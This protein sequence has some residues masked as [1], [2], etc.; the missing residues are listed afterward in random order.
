MNCQAVR[1]HWNLYHDSEGDGELHFRINEHLGACP[2]CAQWFSQ[3]CR[4][5]EL[6]EERL[7]AQPATRE[8]WNQVLAPCGLVR[9]TSTR[10]WLWWAGVAATVLLALAVLR[11]SHDSSPASDLAGLTAARH[12]RL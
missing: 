1:Q 10:H 4:L 11:Y 7:R 8:M 3:Q 9:P 12:Q 2:D 6:L 5:E